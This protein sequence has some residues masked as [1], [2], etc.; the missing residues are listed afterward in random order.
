MEGIGAGE[1]VGEAGKGAGVSGT[2]SLIL[3][4]TT[5]RRRRLRR[6]SPQEAAA[7]FAAE[8]RGL[9]GTLLHMCSYKVLI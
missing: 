5:G 4:R 3:P 8:V 2:P 1:K 6:G 7:A 9:R